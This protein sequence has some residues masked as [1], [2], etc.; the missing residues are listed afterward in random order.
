VTRTPRLAAVAML[1]VLGA[2]A[3]ACSIPT[4]GD[5][6]SVPA[7]KV[8][9]NLLDPH[10]PT[11][12]TTQPKGGLVP[13]QVFFINSSTQQLQAE[14]RYVASPAPLTSIITAM[15]AGP[16]ENETAAVQNAIPSDVSV[17]STNTAPG[18]VVVVN[19]NNAFRQITGVD[20][21]LAVGQI[22]ATVAAASGFG[23]GV[24]F[25][26]DG[27]RTPVP[28]ANGSEVNGPV[29]LIQFLGGPAAA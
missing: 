28:I 18:N 21:Q 26:I 23:T 14:Q 6:S 9:F 17:L 19:M 10:P 11:T 4:Q 27:Q 16:A 13:V 20:Q 2:T 8:P 12:T 7:S 24:V 5:P 29:Y 1:A 25:E 3:A 22:V 15:L